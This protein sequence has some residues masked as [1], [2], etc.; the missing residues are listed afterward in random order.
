[1][2]FKNFNLTPLL[3]LCFFEVVIVV[4]IRRERGGRAGRELTLVYLDPSVT[5]HTVPLSRTYAWA[6]RYRCLLVVTKAHRGHRRHSLH[7]LRK[8][9]LK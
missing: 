8:D 3:I 2:F 4:A 5:G 1:M 6:D 9:G 7:V